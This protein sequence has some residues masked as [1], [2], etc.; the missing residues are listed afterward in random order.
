[1]VEM[2]AE[3][4]VDEIVVLTI[5]YD[6]AARVRSYE[7]LAEAFELDPASSSS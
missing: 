4:E 5:T 2:A 6:F 7:L 1:L 3:Y